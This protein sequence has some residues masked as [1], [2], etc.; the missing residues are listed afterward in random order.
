[1]EPPPIPVVHRSATHWVVA[2]YIRLD[3][4][5]L[6]KLIIPDKTDAPSTQQAA[7]TSQATTAV[8]NQDWDVDN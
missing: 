4:A 1:M 3:S 7:T 6:A 8:E 5:V 2:E